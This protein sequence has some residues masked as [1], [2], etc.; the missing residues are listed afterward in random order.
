MSDHCLEPRFL[1]RAIAGFRLS[2]KDT[3]REQGKW[4]N[5]MSHSEGQIARHLVKEENP[6]VSACQ[7]PPQI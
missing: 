7:L 5:Q 6:P 2:P 4:E 3:A 1:T